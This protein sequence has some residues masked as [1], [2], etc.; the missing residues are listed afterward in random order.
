MLVLLSPAK[1]LD[2]DSPSASDLYSTGEFLDQA[3]GLVR[4]MKGKKPA[5]LMKLMSISEKLADLNVDRFKGYESPVAPGPNAKQ[6]AFAFTGHT[7]VGFNAADMSQS[8]LEFAQTYVRILSGLYGLLRPLDLVYPYRL[9]MGTRLKTRRGNSLYDYWGD[10]LAKA[11]DR[12]LIGH[13]EPLVVNCASK[14]YF[15]AAERPGLKAR[16]VTPVF[17]DKKDDGYKVVSFFAKEARGAMAAHIVRNRIQDVGGIRDFAF[18]G[19]GFS[20]GMSDEDTLVFIRDGK[21]D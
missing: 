10:R 12:E 13:G 9:E 15:T 2:F 18:K 14:E 4:T 7:Y 20:E 21:P 1:S 8:D 17:K 11:I 19:Y 6:A 5:E 3:N 16:V